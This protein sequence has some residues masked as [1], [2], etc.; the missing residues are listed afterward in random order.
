MRKRKI[1]IGT[2]RGIG[3]PY[4]EYKKA[5]NYMWKDETQ[6]NKQKVNI[7]VNVTKTMDYNAHIT[8][9]KKLSRYEGVYLYK[10]GTS[11]QGRDFYAVE[12]DM[13]SDYNKN[14]IMLD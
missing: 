8:I 14:V 6:Y 1:G 4:E 2:L 12:I 7:K 5:M 11:T 3:M 10:I 9:L 13:N